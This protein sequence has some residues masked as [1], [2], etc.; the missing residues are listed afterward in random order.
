M[1]IIIMTMRMNSYRW[2]VAGREAI[3]ITVAATRLVDRGNDRSPTMNKVVN[4]CGQA[5][6]CPL[7]PLAALAVPSGDRSLG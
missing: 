4:K 3:G 7:M 6:V 5:T 2:V 1:K